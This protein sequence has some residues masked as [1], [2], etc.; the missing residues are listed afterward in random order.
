MREVPVPEAGEACVRIRV[1]AAGLNPVDFKTRDG[2]LKVIRRYPLPIALG[3]D[4]AGTVEAWGPGVTRLAVGD[5]VYARVDKDEMGALA[6]YACVHEALVARM[7]TTLDF[8]AAGGVPLAGL[9]ALQALRDELRVA[10]GQRIFIRGGAGGVGTFAVQ[11]AKILGAE[12]GDDG[13]AA[14]CGAGSAARRGR[15]RRLNAA[16]LRGRA[17]RV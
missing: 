17:P 13:V 11:L 10:P 6:E 16:A 12:V 7:P 1:H 14:R 4:L 15:G 5:R 8:D 2:Q 9:T 3:N